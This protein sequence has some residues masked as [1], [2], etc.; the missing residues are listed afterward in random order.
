LPHPT[1]QH[2]KKVRFSDPG[3]LRGKNEDKNP[4]LKQRSSAGNLPVSIM[5]ANILALTYG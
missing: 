4:N 1:Y 3:L 5:T 2:L